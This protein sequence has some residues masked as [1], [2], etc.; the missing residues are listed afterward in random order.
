MKRNWTKANFTDVISFDERKPIL[1]KALQKG[2]YELDAPYLH[3][4]VD[5]FLKRLR[6]CSMPTE[7][8]PDFDVVYG[9]Q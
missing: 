3:D 6:A 7:T 5:A 1:R 4:T 8:F 2:W 9:L